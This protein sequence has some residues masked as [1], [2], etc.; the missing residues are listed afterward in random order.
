M[1]NPDGS[2]TNVSDG[3]LFKDL[4]KFEVGYF[5]WWARKNYTRGD[6]INPVWHPVVRAECETMNREG[7]GQ[8]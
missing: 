5:V 7:V 8:E 3:P 4:T 6:D 2:Y 1:I